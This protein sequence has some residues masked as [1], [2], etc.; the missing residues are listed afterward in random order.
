[1]KA[2]FPLML[3]TMACTFVNPGT[4]LAGPFYVVVATFST[5]PGARQFAHSLQSTFE[6]ASFR[7]DGKKELYYVHLMETGRQAE[8]ENFRNHLQDNFGFRDAWIYANLDTGAPASA[9]ERDDSYVKLEL[10]TG[11]S[12]L[13]NSADNTYV[14]VSKRHG[15]KKPT[16][17]NRPTPVEQAFVFIAETRAG[18]LIPAKVSVSDTKGNLISVFKTGEPVAVGGKQDSRVLTLHCDVPGFNAITKMINLANPATL[19]IQPDSAG[20]WEVRF[21]L[22]RQKADEVALVYHH[23]FYGDAA[24]F[25]RAASKTMD[26]LVGALKGNPAAKIVIN[27]H[28]NAGE[29]RPIKLSGGDEHSFD[30]SEALEKTGSDK[31]LTKARAEALRN[32]LVGQ[33]IEAKRISLFGWGSMNLLVNSAADNRSL[34]DRVEVQFISGL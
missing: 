14:S 33:G 6:Q 4:A 18:T 8:A 12:V 9:D 25:E 2:L 5:E 21:T 34:N 29:K 11:G 23:M 26:V 1:M 22:T 24:I 19:D 17:E 13:L 31:L 10:H 15:E 16:I 30:L 3:L 20:I 7:F 28:C 32:Y 27:S